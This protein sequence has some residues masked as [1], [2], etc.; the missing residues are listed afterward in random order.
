MRIWLATATSATLRPR[1]LAIRSNCSRSGPDP[2]V[3]IFCAASTKAQRS[4]G[5]PWRE[6]CLVRALPSE[7][8]TVGA[9]PAQ[10]HRCRA[11]QRRVTSPTST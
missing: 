2:V 10:E 11:L 6:M 9:S 1:R 7:L 4:A 5:E 3:V 8:R